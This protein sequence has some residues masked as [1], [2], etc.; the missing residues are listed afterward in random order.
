MAVCW[1][2]PSY[3][4]YIVD[5][6]PGLVPPDRHI[7]LQDGMSVLFMATPQHLR[8]MCQGGIGFSPRSLLDL[9]SGVWTFARCLLFGWA[10][11]VI[12]FTIRPGMGGWG[13]SLPKGRGDSGAPALVSG[14]VSAPPEN[15][16]EMLPPC[17]NAL[18]N[19][20]EKLEK[21]FPIFP[22]T[23]YDNSYF[24]MKGGKKPR[25][26]VSNEPKRKKIL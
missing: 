25:K 2:F 21:T 19:V 6:P 15:K 23:F 26:K 1:A 8:E 4:P 11:F 10:P 16:K 14:V 18:I 9:K 7:V 12:L 22:L 17:L 5:A 3:Q 20:Q 24:Q 13:G